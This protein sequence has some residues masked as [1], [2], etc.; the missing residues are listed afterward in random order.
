[1]VILKLVK[2]AAGIPTEFDGQ[3]VRRYDPTFREADGRYA[4]GILE[5]TRDR[6]QALQFE[7]AGAALAKWREPYG[8]RADGE[9][10][11]PLAAWTVEIEAA[12]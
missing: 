5:T 6:T 1:M 2:T 9:P 4:G 12:P 10:N 11:R 3:Y 7:D 8:M